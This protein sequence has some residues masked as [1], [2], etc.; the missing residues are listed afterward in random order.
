MHAAILAVTLAISACRAGSETMD[1]SEIEALVGALFAAGQGAEWDAAL[2]LTNAAR[3]SDTPFDITLGK[4][5]SVTVLTPQ[6]FVAAKDAVAII[7]IG[8][9]RYVWRPK[10]AT[11]VDAFMLE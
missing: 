7:S 5:N 11:A 3:D 2:A 10:D 4:P 6:E 1:R 8:D 9:L